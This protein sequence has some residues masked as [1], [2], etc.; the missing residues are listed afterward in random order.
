MHTAR[1][2][3]SGGLMR[4]IAEVAKFTE[5]RESSWSF[6]HLLRSN[7]RRVAD[8]VLY[9]DAVVLAAEAGSQKDR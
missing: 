6:R 3:G 8:A 1:Q 5:T 4:Q 7:M 9:A 2:E